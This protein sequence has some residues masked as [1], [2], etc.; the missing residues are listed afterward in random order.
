MNLFWVVLELEEIRGN[1]NETGLKRG[2]MHRS[3]K[4]TSASIHYNNNYNYYSDT[5]NSQT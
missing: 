4:T 1:G 3:R 2:R 5:I